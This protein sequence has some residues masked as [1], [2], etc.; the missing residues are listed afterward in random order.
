MA[1]EGGKQRNPERNRP[2]PEESKKEGRARM[3]ANPAE[4]Q[5]RDPGQ[6]DPRKGRCF[7]AVLRHPKEDRTG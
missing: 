3:K 5:G 6:S 4:S 7:N 2:D 1:K